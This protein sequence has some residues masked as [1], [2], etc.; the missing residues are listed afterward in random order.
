MGSRAARWRLTGDSTCRTV[1]S[2]SGSNSPQMHPVAMHSFSVDSRERVLVTNSEAFCAVVDGSTAPLAFV[3]LSYKSTDGVVAYVCR[4][5]CANSNSGVMPQAAESGM[6]GRL[7]T[8]FLL[9]RSQVP[10]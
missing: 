2:P 5:C 1:A 4:S 8:A 3:G 10:S 7:I 6:R 9:E